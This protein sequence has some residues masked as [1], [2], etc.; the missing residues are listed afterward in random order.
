MVASNALR[1]RSATAR[2]GVPGRDEIGPR[3]RLL[4]DD[5]FGH[6]AAVVVLDEL[7]HRRHAGLGQLGVRA[8]P[9]LQQD[10]ELAVAD[11]VRLLRL[12]AR[13]VPAAHA[14]D[15]A[16]LHR[17]RDVERALVAGDD[18]ELRVGRAL[19]IM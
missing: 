9:D 10:V 19:E 6:L 12:H 8:R 17:E 1:S 4:A 5:D 3:E 16:A 2:R 11:P 7:P 18:V 15:L 14:V 13:P